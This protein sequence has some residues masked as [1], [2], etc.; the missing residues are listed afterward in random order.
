[1]DADKNGTW[2]EGDYYLTS[3]GTKVSYNG[4]TSF[5]TAAY[6]TLS[7]FGGKTWSNVQTVFNNSAAGKFH[8]EYQLPGD[9]TGNIVQSDSVSFNITFTLEQS[10]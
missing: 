10:H 1:M 7:S 3:D 5:P 2:S 4:E 8:V 9:T 6:A